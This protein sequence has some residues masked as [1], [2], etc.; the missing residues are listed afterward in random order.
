MATVSCIGGGVAVAN[1]SHADYKIGNAMK[2]RV[3]NRQPQLPPN[4]LKS[5]GVTSL[6]ADQPKADD[7]CN[8]LDTNTQ[9]KID[10]YPITPRVDCRSSD[11]SKFNVPVSAVCT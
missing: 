7:K 10:L 6:D 9:L 1:E 5:L 8:E 2:Q 3:I 11:D 4:I